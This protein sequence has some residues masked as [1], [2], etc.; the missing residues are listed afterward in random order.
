VRHDANWLGGACASLLDERLVAACVIVVDV[1]VDDRVNRLGGQ[2]PDRRDHLWRYG[3]GC[4][5][6]EQHAVLA[7]LDSDV[8]ATHY[9][10]VHITLDMQQAH[11]WCRGVLPAG[12][13]DS[14]DTKGDCD[15]RE[16][17]ASVTRHARGGH[18]PV[19][20]RQPPNPTQL[21]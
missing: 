7:N 9:E 19:T 6:H 4:C 21:Q 13:R 2:R 11:G 16:C 20:E 18:G 14:G 10:H 17:R 8:H 1:R 15:E 12:L 5:I 3:G